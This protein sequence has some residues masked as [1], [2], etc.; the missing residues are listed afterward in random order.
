MRTP[1]CRCGG[2]RCPGGGWGWGS[3][4]RKRDGGRPVKGVMV[5]VGVGWG[6]GVG[7]KSRRVGKVKNGGC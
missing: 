2:Q 5:W 3:E 6:L 7:L 4:D 1:R